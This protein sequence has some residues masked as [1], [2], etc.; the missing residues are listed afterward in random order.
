MS[1]SRFLFGGK[2]VEPLRQEPEAP[3]MNATSRDLTAPT[4]LRLRKC[5]ARVAAFLPRRE[6][7][8]SKSRD[9]GLYL[10]DPDHSRLI[11]P[12]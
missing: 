6:P 7:G 10:L 11:S 3:S 12:S 5:Q 1:L 4:R 9:S 8:D 2:L